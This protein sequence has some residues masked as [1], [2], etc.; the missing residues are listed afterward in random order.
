MTHPVPSIRH[1]D[2]FA[3]HLCH[4][5]GLIVL[6]RRLGEVGL[7]G[8]P[9]KVGAPPA[10][11]LVTVAVQVRGNWADADQ[12]LLPSGPQR[13]PAVA[14]D[15]RNRDDPFGPGTQVVRGPYREVSAVAARQRT[16]TRS[17]QGSP[18]PLS[19]RRSA[20][21]SQVPPAGVRQPR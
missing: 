19:G 11:T 2:P 16:G 13:F 9:G 1:R 3:P 15:R 21:R 8:E 12:Q 17:S 7:P 6:R 10:P 20:P 4:A 5:D 14:R 18:P